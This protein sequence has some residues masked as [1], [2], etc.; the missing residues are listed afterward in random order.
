M[1]QPSIM[2]YKLVYI[3]QKKRSRFSIRSESIRIFL[4]NQ[5]C[6]Y[7]CLLFYPSITIILSQRILKESKTLLGDELSHLH[8]CKP[9][10]S[11][12]R[13]SRIFWIHF[14]EIFFFIFIE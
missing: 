6:G 11:H 10:I 12:G 9:T 14:H 1:R 13:T 3:G 5:I 7:S 8:K 2:R 4:F